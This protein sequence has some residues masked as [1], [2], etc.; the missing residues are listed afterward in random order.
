LP[1]GPGL[2]TLTVFATDPWGNIGS[3]SIQVTYQVPDDI[4]P[5]ARITSPAD[6]ATF[7]ATPIEVSGT[8]DDDTATVVVN[9]AT[10]TVSDGT[11]STSGIGLVEGTN[12]ITVTATDPAGNESTDS[13]QVT[14]E[15]AVAQTKLYFIHN[16]HLGTPQL[17]TDEAGIYRMRLFTSED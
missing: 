12:T 4:P 13:I 3:D 7:T 8:I 14:Y 17:L 1:L 16:D 11:F 6:G 2:N 10:A 15:P 9:G 5:V